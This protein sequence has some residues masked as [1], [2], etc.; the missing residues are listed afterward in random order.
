MKYFKYLLTTLLALFLVTPAFA[1]PNGIRGA[2]VRKI[3][4]DTTMLDDKAWIFG[5]SSDFHLE[6]D[7]GNGYLQLSDGTNDFLRITDGGT[8]AT[9]TFLGTVQASNAAG[10]TLLDEATTSTNPTIIPNRADPDTGVGWKA[11]DQVSLVAG[12]VEGIRVTE[13]AGT[14][15]IDAYGTITTPRSATPSVTFKDSDCTDSDINAKTYADATDTG[16]TAED[17]DVFFQQQIAG[18]LTTWLQADADGNIDFQDRLLSTGGVYVDE[19][20]TPSTVSGYGCFYTKT[21]DKP[22]FKD[23][24]G[25]EHEVATTSSYYAAMYLNNNSNAEVIST[26]AYPVL[27]MNF[28]AGSL[29]GFTF[30]AGRIVDAD[31]ASEADATQLEVTTSAAHNLTT[32]DIVSQTGMNNAAHNGVTTVTVT[33]ATTYTC[34]QIAYAGNAGA[35]SGDIV[36]GSHLIAGTGAAG[37][38]SICWHLS[39]TPAAASIYK[40]QIHK[41][42]TACT[43]CVGQRKFPNN[44]QGNIVGGGIATIAD[45]DKIYIGITCTDGTNNIVN[46]YGNFSLHRL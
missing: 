9:F 41:N 16:T 34:D 8:T 43:T 38:Y 23:G 20:T 30:D 29:S 6:Y 22:Y 42:Y 11:A 39:V 4:Y 32:G 27:L 15:T 25:N 10:P 2:F 19:I 37:M 35:S 1:G 21:D 24:A 36:E 13:S 17:V 5:T 28:T 7:S 31:I 26:A 40:A 18:S 33:A 44:D 45:A 46:Q 14:I 3:P 12:G